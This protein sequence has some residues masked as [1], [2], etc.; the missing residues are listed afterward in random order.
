MKTPRGVNGSLIL[1]LPP[2]SVLLCWGRNESK[3]MQNR[4]I[5]MPI[6][7]STSKPRLGSWE[8]PGLSLAEPRTGGK[9]QALESQQGC[10]VSHP[11]F[12]ADLCL[13]AS[14]WPNKIISKCLSWLSDVL[15]QLNENTHTHTQI[16]TIIKMGLEC[17]LKKITAK[18]E[19]T[20]RSLPRPVDSRRVQSVTVGT[21]VCLKNPCSQQPS[22]YHP[23]WSEGLHHQCPGLHF[24]SLI[25]RW[26]SI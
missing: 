3:W 16:F 18:Y 14:E 20:H 11:S 17:N 1:W 12:H 6:K 2:A 4:Q 24:S 8:K 5:K 7:C 10:W 25:C 13:F 22:F 19:Q 23:L 26:K 9:M 21:E 15:G